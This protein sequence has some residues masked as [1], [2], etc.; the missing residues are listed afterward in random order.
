MNKEKVFQGHNVP[1]F[2]KPEIFI[3]ISMVLIRGII[4]IRKCDQA[5]GS[6]LES[7]DFI[8]FGSIMEAPSLTSIEH[9]GG[10]DRVV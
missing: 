4:L 6:I 10:E 5:E 2:E 3:D 1:E 7:L 8:N 9:V